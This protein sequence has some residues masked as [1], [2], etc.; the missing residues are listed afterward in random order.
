MLPIEQSRFSYRSRTYRRGQIFEALPARPAPS[1]L[2][3]DAYAA[4]YMQ[5]FWPGS[6]LGESSPESETNS[7]IEA[8][9]IDDA[10][11]FIHPAAIALHEDDGGSLHAHARS[12]LP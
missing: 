10:R 11:S 9:Q 1:V 8:A 2:D 3:G 6:Q 7:F 12:V 5:Q 4:E